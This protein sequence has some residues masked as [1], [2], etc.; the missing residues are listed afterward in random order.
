MKIGICDDHIEECNTIR[1]YCIELDQTDIILYPSGEHLLN[2]PELNTLNLL[3]LDIELTGITGI[4]VKNILEAVC[5]TTLIVFT[6]AHQELMPNAFGH[7]VISF[8]SKPCTKHAIEYCINKAAYLTNEFFPITVN[9]KISVPCKNILYLHS[10]QKYTVFYVTGGKN[11]STRKAMK[12]WAEELKEFHFCP[13]SRSAIINLKHFR[14][15]KNKHAV[16]NENISL[17]VSRRYLQ[18]LTDKYDSYL[19]HLIQ[20]Q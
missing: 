16:L 18:P 11:Y 5:S 15:T 14:Y 1:N 9:D 7:N 6:T 17:P 10:E 2:S 13:I 12:E 4:H 3:F 8:L 19:K 20:Y